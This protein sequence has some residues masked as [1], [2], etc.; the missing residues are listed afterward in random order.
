MIDEEKKVRF[1][2]AQ[3]IPFGKSKSRLQNI[4][5]KVH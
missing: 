2:T 5:V 3:L 4:T 1:F